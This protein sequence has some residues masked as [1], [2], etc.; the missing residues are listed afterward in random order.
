MVV[1]L[2]AFFLLLLFYEVALCDCFILYYH[3]N[4]FC[5]SSKFKKF[6]MVMKGNS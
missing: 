5:L 4:I 1:H 6:V 2:S 3:G